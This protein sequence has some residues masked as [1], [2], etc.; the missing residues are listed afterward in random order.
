MVLLTLLAWVRTGGNGVVG[1]VVVIIKIGLRVVLL[2]RL[3]LAAIALFAEREIEVV[4]LE[5][6][7]IL[8]FPSA[9][10]VR[11]TP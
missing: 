4:T 6:N 11:L 2:A 10:H 7:P 8:S 1:S 3:H 9:S 5:A